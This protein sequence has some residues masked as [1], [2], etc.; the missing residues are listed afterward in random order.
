MSS[1]RVFTGNFSQ[2][3]HP[4]EFSSR[5][6]LLGAIILIAHITIL[7]ALAQIRICNTIS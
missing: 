7:L 5:N 6:E 2:E 3:Y 4:K 1:E